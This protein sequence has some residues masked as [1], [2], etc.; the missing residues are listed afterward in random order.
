MNKIVGLGQFQMSFGKAWKIDEYQ[1]HA[2][3]LFCMMVTMQKTKT[4]PTYGMCRSSCLITTYHGLLLRNVVCFI[5]FSVY[6]DCLD[7]GTAINRGST[8][9]FMI[10]KLLAC[11]PR[12]GFLNL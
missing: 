12:F 8:F 6:Q 4:I 10:H 7:L 1:L 3:F 2:L 9:F 11:K 5:Q